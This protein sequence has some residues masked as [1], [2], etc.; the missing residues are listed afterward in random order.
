MSLRFFRFFFIGFTSGVELR[1][2]FRTCIWFDD[3]L[4]VRGIW[5]GGFGFEGFEGFDVL[6]RDEIRTSI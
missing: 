3:W 6:E 2:V 5:T 4:R 1:F